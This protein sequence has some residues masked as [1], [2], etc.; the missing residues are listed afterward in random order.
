MTSAWLFNKH[1]CVDPNNL[2]SNFSCFGCPIHKS[3]G[4]LRA[5]PL[6]DLAVLC[7]VEASLAIP[8][9]SPVLVPMAQSI[10]PLLSQI[11]SSPTVRLGLLEN[12]NGDD[13]DSLRYYKQKW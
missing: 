1:P 11:T 10:G 4:V 12:D 7:C 8:L 13:G 5:T 2:L 6:I 3:T 9:F